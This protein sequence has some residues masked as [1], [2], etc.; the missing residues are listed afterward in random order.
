V[1]QVYLHERDAMNAKLYPGEFA[2]KL[3][4]WLSELTT[5][6]R[7]VGKPQ[8]WTLKGY[9]LAHK[10]NP[11]T[12]MLWFRKLEQVAKGLYP[13]RVPPD[14]RDRPPLSDE[15]VRIIRD[16]YLATGKVLKIARRYKIEP[17]RVGLIC[18]AEKQRR[19]GPSDH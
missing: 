16:E 17:W 15:E 5:N 6:Q 10:I 11:G 7:T 18:R 19:I 1:R 13:D 4:L 2:E 12:F 9:A 8:Y 3:E 14:R